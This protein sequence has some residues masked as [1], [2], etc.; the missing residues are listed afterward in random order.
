MKES[1]IDTDILSYYMR[2]L[3]K[4]IPRAQKYLRQFGHFNVSSLTVFE[5]LKGLRKK[6]LVEK[7][8]I[9][10][11]EIL[12][13]QVFALDYAV[14]DTA[15]TLLTVLEDKGTPIAYGDLFVASTAL[16][17]DLILVTNNTKHFSKVEGLV[18]E[19][20]AKP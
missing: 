14:M 12:K 15:A 11:T 9:F 18:L 6:K 7:E 16:A 3:Q 2:G 5:I 8:E 19:N 1:L 17:H 13:H 20:W 4:V 10:Q